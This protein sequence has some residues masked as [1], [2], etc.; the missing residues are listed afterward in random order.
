MVGLDDPRVGVQ[1]ADDLPGCVDLLGGCIGDLVQDHHIREL[2]LIREKVHERAL[3][4]FTHGLAPVTQEV[5]TGI[6]LEQIHRIHDGYHRVEA[7]DVRKAIAR[8][9]TEIGR[10]GDG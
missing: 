8:L 3:V 2:D 9:D 4:L 6:V 1:A 10:R 7:G 5:V